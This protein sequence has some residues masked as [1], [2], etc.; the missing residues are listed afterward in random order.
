[1]QQYNKALQEMKNFYDAVKENIKEH[2][3]NRSQFPDHPQ[4]LLIIG[5]SGSGKTNSLFH[6][7]NQQPDNGI[8]LYA[9]DPYERKYLFLTKKREDVETK[10][11][12]DSKTFNEYSN[13][14]DDIYKNIEEY[15]LYENLKY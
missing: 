8:Y 7:I 10:D 6:L 5:R 3:P 11:F 14:M 12:N 13:D 4:R 2:N 9:Q 15:N 1:M